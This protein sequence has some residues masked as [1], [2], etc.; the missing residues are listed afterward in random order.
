MYYSD[1]EDTGSSD[2]EASSNSSSTSGDSDDDLDVL[3]S[4]KS[5]TP[6]TTPIVAAG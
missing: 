6:V 3:R 5:D 1:G 2:S 4:V